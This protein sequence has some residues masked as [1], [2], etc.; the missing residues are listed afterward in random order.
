MVKEYIAQHQERFLQELFDL[1][2]IPSVSADSKFKTDVRKAA[3]YVKARL[4]EA[5]AS[6]VELVETKGHPIVF[7]EKIINRLILYIYGHRLHSSL[8]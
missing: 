8:L 6:K 2:R 3:E 4:V 5:G 1:L 7:G